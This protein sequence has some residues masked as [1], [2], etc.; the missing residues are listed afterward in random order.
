MRIV[1]YVVG[2]PPDRFPNGVVSA[3]ASLA[4]ALRSA[5]CD[6]RILAQYGEA[7]GSAGDVTYVDARSV[8]RSLAHR[9]RNRLSPGWELFEAAPRLMAQRINDSPDLSAA[10]VVEMEESFGW[11]GVIAPRIGPP[12]ITRLHGPYFLTGAAANDAGFSASESERILR[13]GAGIRAATAV[14]APSRFVLDAVRNH[15]S[16]A[17]DEAT[18]IPNAALPVDPA[19]IW[20]LAE[21]DPNEV[22]FVGR[23]DR[24]KGADLLLRAF[25]ELAASRPQLKLTFAGPNDLPL[26][27]DGKDWACADFVRSIMP[28][29]IAARIDFLGMVPFS[30]LGRLRQRALLTVVCSRIEMFANVVLEAMAHGSPVAA[31]KVGG[32]PEIITDGAD[33]LLAA[34]E[35][36][37]IAKAVATLLDSPEFAAQLGQRG[38]RRVESD[39]APGR[40]AEMTLAKYR[41]VVERRASERAP[42]RAGVR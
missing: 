21:A 1:Y 19:E 13:E 4:P 16:L 10:D 30:E 36:G 11:S 6:V 32:V 15:Y 33:G 22:L 8:R 35:S 38:R 23:F 7:D 20:R 34:A 9:L 2:W 14:S 24:I 18:V 29:D 25:A 26:R 39:Y 12:V 5:G 31:T 37:A 40:I 28:P 17:L 3:T 42:R 41:D 27:V